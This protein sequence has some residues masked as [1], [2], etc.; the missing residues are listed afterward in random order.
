MTPGEDLLQ[1]TVGGNVETVD[2]DIRIFHPS[3]RNGEV[4]LQSQHGLEVTERPLR[5]VLAQALAG[6]LQLTAPP[7]PNRDA[8]VLS[9]LTSEER[10]HVFAMQRH[11]LDVIHGRPPGPGAGP[12]DSTFEER[13]RRQA[14]MEELGY[15]RDRIRRLIHRWRTKGLRGLIH[16]NR[17]LPTD[18]VEEADPDVV[19]VVTDLVRR[20]GPASKKT[21]VNLHAT[22]LSDL[23]RC[24]IAR[25]PADS[26]RPGDPSKP[27]A[28]DLLHETTF[29]R[30]YV[31]LSG[32]ADPS[33]NAKTRQSQARRP[34]T[35]PL[36]HRAVDF[37]DVVEIDS[38]PCD[39][40]VWSPEGRR[41]PHAVFAV[42]VA[43]KIM[44]IRLT[45]G[46]PGAGDLAM[47][48]HDMINPAPRTTSGGEATPCTVPK[49]VV[50]HADPPQA[51]G[52][53]PVLP[54][55]IVLDHGS[56]G[57]NTHFISLL[58]QL[59]I[60]VDWAR[61]RS[62]TDKPHVESL[63]ATFAHASQLVPGHRGN[64]VQNHGERID[65]QDLLSMA[66]AKKVFRQWSAFAS[67]QPHTG[68]PNRM[69]P[70]RFLTPNEALVT[71]LARGVPLRVPRDPDLVMRFLPYIC[72]VPN[73]EGVVYNK[74]TYW[75]EDYNDLRVQSAAAG[76]GRENLIF[77]YDPDDPDRLFWQDPR[78]GHWRVLS[79][80][81]ADG[82]PVR[83]FDDLHEE[84]LRATP[85]RQRLTQSATAASESHLVDG[86]RTIADAD[87]DGADR[88]SRASRGVAP[89]FTV[90]SDPVDPSLGGW[91]LE[92]LRALTESPGVDEDDDLDLP[93]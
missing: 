21:L 33:Q 31:A 40:E 65:D 30:L 28:E 34:T 64:A 92:D 93:W 24:G 58:A 25:T 35:G 72:R 36:R 20:E 80:P 56:E 8:E 78:R 41:K 90:H 76:R 48:L 70:S 49:R 17:R 23:R 60:Q 62:P 16:G 39:F 38:T 4:Y 73:P 29:R 83:P 81:G 67:D 47:L 2:G 12:Y 13:D 27:E 55:L 85:G 89:Q 50:V 88:V 14:K 53:P 42:D 59:G 75:C 66:A 3:V 9:Q 1:V 15:D 7:L 87:A 19:A 69:F 74:I 22:A 68:L 11:V 52:P 32:G 61:T 91:D 45:D 63:I 5:E 71:S 57:E 54:G 51:A 46:P 37:G 77:H 84:R 26:P 6:N 43:T 10:E 18:V 79:A 82:N 44:W 86:I